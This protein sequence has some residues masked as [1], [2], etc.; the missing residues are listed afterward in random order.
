MLRRAQAAIG[1]ARS[2]I[3]VESTRPSSAVF[4]TSSV[5]Q[6]TPP[7]DDG[8][9]PPE[10]SFYAHQHQW[11]DKY[12][13][14][15]NVMSIGPRYPAVAA[16]AYIA[17]SAVVAGDVDIMDGVSIMHG[18]VVRGDLNNIKIGFFSSVQENCVI[19]AARH[20]ASTGMPANTSI[21]EAVTVGAGSMLRSCRVHSMVSIGERCIIMEGSVIESESALQAGTVVPPAKYI[22]SGELW[23]GN[24][25]QF[26]RKLTHDEK[27]E[28]AQLTDEHEKWREL[29]DAEELPHGVLWKRAE[30]VDPIQD[31]IFPE[32]D[33]PD[34]A[35][36]PYVP[37]KEPEAAS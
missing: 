9:L 19:H 27:L 8:W 20:A 26:V 13:R 12:C 15:R 14:Q 3:A 25:A 17:P 31:R 34:W 18:A 4:S 5:S 28:I 35:T 16:S 29:H 6:G 23:G 1:A 36:L 33:A 10:P 21:G 24:P 30:A 37:A 11:H 2:L 7:K 32:G 22:P